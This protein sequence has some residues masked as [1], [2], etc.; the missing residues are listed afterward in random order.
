LAP[1]RPAG[2]LGRV[3]ERVALITGGA[4]GIGR[5]LAR[6]LAADGWAVAFCYRT[7]QREAAALQEELR[8]A[9]ARALAL[10]CDVSDADA[11]A[12]LVAAVDA[13]W[14]R[15]DALVNCAG[16]YHRVALLEESLEGWHAMFDH[17][18]HPVFYLS[19]LVAP[20]MQARGFGRILTFA[21][22]NADRLGGQTHVTAY[23]IAKAAL[24]ILTRSLAKTL[25]G[26]GI[27]ANAISPGFL[28]SGGS[29]PEELDR[30]LHAIPA[31]YVGETGDAVAVARFLLS[32]AARYVNGTNVHVSGAW[33]I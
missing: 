30:M 15:I 29:P 7:S 17:N 10:Q 18:L 28:D 22:A 1:R 4:K 27:T 26:H 14:G 33:G 8:A 16:P 2:K 11:C 21:M 19:R 6:N 12:R 23:Y 25:A 32:E 3:H 9:G 13:E 5:A 20:G 24:L 31:G